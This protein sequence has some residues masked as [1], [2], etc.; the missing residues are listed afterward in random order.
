MKEEKKI[1][2]KIN[3]LIAGISF[4]VKKK[5]KVLVFSLLFVSYCEYHSLFQFVIFFYIV[6]ISQISDNK[7]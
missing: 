7:I 2:K 5:K 6:F 4:L 1:K 3:L